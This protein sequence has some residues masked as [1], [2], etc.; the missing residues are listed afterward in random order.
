MGP[1]TRGGARRLAC[2]GLSYYGPSAR[3]LVTGRWCPASGEDA[4]EVAVY[5]TTKSAPIPFSRCNTGIYGLKV[6]SWFNQCCMK[7]LLMIC[8]FAWVSLDALGDS[9]IDLGGKLTTFTNLQGHVYEGVRLEKA[10]LDGVIYTVTNGVGGGMVRFKDLSTNF[11]ADL[12][13]PA[14][15]LQ[16][17][18]QRE[19]KNAAMTARYNAEV[20]ALALKQE[21]QEALAQSNALAQA[22][23]N[24]KTAAATTQSAARKSHPKAHPR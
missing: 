19:Q 4:F 15:R 7:T 18:A 8:L 10:T 14:D 5:Q 20:Q 16:I 17:A 21:Q 24:A 3:T 23:A 6:R 22:S 11:L 1:D 12:H 9:D 13:I 2:P